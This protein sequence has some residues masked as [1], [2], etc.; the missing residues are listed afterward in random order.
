MS[1]DNELIEEWYVCFKD[2]E[3]KHWIQRV[4]KPGFEHC[5]AFK[6]SPGG[7]FYIVLNPAYSHLDVDLL[8]I[9]EEN[10]AKL[11]NNCKFVKVIVKY[12]A[13]LKRGSICH[14][15][16]VEVVKALIGVK[17]FFVFTPYQLYK[18][19]IKWAIQ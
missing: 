4:L 16:C 14:F 3:V 6:T 2:A 7:Q 8:N 12:D 15:N 5:Y 19:I 9:N 10:F 11:T 13:K 17:G 18:R 1:L